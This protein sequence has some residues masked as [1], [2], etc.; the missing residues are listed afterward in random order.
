MRRVSG[1][2][3]GSVVP[4]IVTAVGSLLAVAAHAATFTSTQWSYDF[5]HF[6]LT[7]GVAGSPESVASDME[8][9]A[10][11]TST[12][13]NAVSGNE[14]WSF[15]FSGTGATKGTIYQY[16]TG[17]QALSSAWYRTSAENYFTGRIGF[18]TS[19]TGNVG[20]LKSLSEMPTTTDPVRFYFNGLGGPIVTSP[21][22]QGVQWQFRIQEGAT[23]RISIGPPNATESATTWQ[24]ITPF[25]T[26]NTGVAYVPG[27][28]ANVEL[29][30]NLVDSTGTL[31]LNGTTIYS[32]VD[33]VGASGV[34]L[35]NLNNFNLFTKG[36]SV[37]DFG[38]QV[39]P[40]PTSLLLGA[41]GLAG[42][43]LAVRRRRHCLN[44]VSIG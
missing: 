19:G 4:A 41:V 3:S 9:Q 29:L 8:T 40:E 33:L 21:S 5:N 37:I 27:Q 30:M 31:K 26:R 12:L 18:A 34:N 36:G 1:L 25:G 24:F 35:R 22:G 23:D 32:D 28:L 39:V 7:Q 15:G 2:L 13:P 14:G 44:R 6:G 20:N 17:V 42:G 38:A 16:A 43:L 10:S 11:T